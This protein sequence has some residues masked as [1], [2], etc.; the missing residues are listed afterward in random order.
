MALLLFLKGASMGSVSNN[1][2][3]TDDDA[4]LTAAGGP[5]DSSEP[6]TAA[7]DGVER[8]PVDNVDN[9]NRVTHS[10]EADEWLAGGA[11]EAGYGY[12]V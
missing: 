4:R 5:G 10:K 6:G 7:G 12:G 11:E 1:P 9:V 3:A 2:A 8:S